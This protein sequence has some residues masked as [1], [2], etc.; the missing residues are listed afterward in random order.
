MTK[1]PTRAEI[2]ATLTR[3]AEAGGGELA[4][5]IVRRSPV[6]D[7]ACGRPGRG[8]RAGGQPGERTP[9]PELR[10]PRRKPASTSEVKAPADLLLPDRHAMEAYFL[11]ISGGKRDDAIARAQQIMYDAWNK[12][13]SRSRVALAHK[14]LGISPLC[15]DAYNLL[16]GEAATATEARD[17]YVRG[18]MAG[19]LALGPQG[20]EEY[21]VHFWG[22]L[23]TRPYMR[24]RH[25]LALTLL[26]LGE[27]GAA[28]EH[29]RAM[30][31]LNPNDNQGIRYLLLA[32]LL[33][34]DDISAVK[35][36]LA[37]YPD[38]WSAY[39]L[40]TRALVAFRDGKASTTA[41][42]KL[43]KDARSANEHVPPILAGTTPL[44]SSRSGYVTVGGADE[45]SNYVRE[46]G[47][48]WERTPGAIGWLAATI[49]TAGQTRHRIS[50][51]T[52]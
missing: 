15:A 52:H 2:D 22:F 33:R 45:A 29:F 50:K 18:L 37:E 27:E 28:I 34:R 42:L 24:A 40:Y 23:E 11:E 21:G 1:R 14:A 10:K 26:E 32:S 8:A 4:G 49:S 30:L 47:A 16:A 43:L 12:T 3:M 19:E 35:K 51:T 6:M 46:C 9:M 13:T 25:G 20:F 44:T 5:Y 38:E 7:P 31:K 39:W 36:L 17:L 41:T 48:A